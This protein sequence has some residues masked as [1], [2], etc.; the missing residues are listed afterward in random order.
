MTQAPVYHPLP[1]IGYPDAWYAEHADKAKEAGDR[2]ALCTVK[3]GQ[4]ITLGKRKNKTW[5]EKLKAFRHALK[6]Y[7]VPPDNAE[8]SVLEF[9]HRLTEMIQRVAGDEALKI[10]KAAN[11]GWTMR[12]ALG[13][14]KSILSDEADALFLTLTGHCDAKPDWCS[15]EAWAALHIIRDKWV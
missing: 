12:R 3:V 9:H 5:E 7:C 8:A 1:V 13:V 15:R 2:F 10:A 6:H 4:Y 11:D 14:E